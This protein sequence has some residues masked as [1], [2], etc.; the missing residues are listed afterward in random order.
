VPPARRHSI[1]FS[2][3]NN[4]QGAFAGAPMGDR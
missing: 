1:E 4:F 3:I 2:E